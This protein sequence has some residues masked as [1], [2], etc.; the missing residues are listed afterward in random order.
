MNLTQRKLSPYTVNT[1]IAAINGFLIFMGLA[2]CR[3]KM[4]KNPCPQPSWDRAAKRSERHLTSSDMGVEASLPLRFFVLRAI[5][6]Y[7]FAKT[8]KKRT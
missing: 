8:A 1:K 5:W 3:L 4:L 6:L 2:D 7:I